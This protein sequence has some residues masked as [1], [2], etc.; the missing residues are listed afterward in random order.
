MRNSDDPGRR[1]PHGDAPDPRFAIS[2]SRDLAGCY[3]GL[4][5]NIKNIKLRNSTERLAN[6]LLA[7]RAIDSSGSTVILHHEKRILASPR[8]D[9][10]KS[11]A[12]VCRPANGVSVQGSVVTL[13]N[14]AALEQLAKPDPLIDNNARAAILSLKR[15]PRF[16]YRN[17]GGQS[18][19]EPGP[20]WLTSRQ[21]L[22]AAVRE[23]NAMTS[24]PAGDDLPGAA[25]RVARERPELWKRCRRWAKRQARLVRS[26]PRRRLVTLALAIGADS[27]GR[28]AFSRAP[29]SGRAKRR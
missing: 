24:E 5:R 8:H 16:G 20:L 23:S 10:G 27:G 17:S 28:D 9:A 4:V 7:Q 26:T 13:A 14:T 3:R 22:S 1:D 2:V 19:D 25:G 12:L 18:R 11:L 29:R 15:T 6:H 21:P